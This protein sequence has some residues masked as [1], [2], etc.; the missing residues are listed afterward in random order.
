MTELKPTVEQPSPRGRR[1]VR[2]RRRSTPRAKGMRAGRLPYL[3]IV[4]AVAVLVVVVA[5]PLL[6]IVTLSLQ[7]QDSSK[8]ALFHGGGGTKFVG[9]Q[10]FTHVLGDAT[11]WAVLGR[12]FVFTA[13]NVA[14]SLM[15]GM[16]LAVLLNRVSKWARVILIVV[17]L[18]VWAVPST[19]STQVFYW[20]FSNQYGAVNYLLDQI[21]GVHMHGH[22]WF[23]DPHQGLAVISAVV[24]WG[25]IPLLA[26]SL[27]AGI[28]QIPKEIQEAAYC[29]GASAWQ[30]FRSVTFPFLKPLIVILTTLSVIWDFGV[31]NQIWF[32]RNGHPEP[33][34]QTIGIYMYS[35]GIGSSHYN[36]GATT[37]VLMMIC[38][39]FVMVFYIRQLFRIGDA[40]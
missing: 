8:Y 22:D 15:I 35:N 21:P 5:W 10:N 39:L 18:F 2:D 37:G 23:A 29:D 34:Y 20:L 27:H 30:T 40:E 19:V 31:F 28:T 7:K 38:L 17:L 24:I 32:M 11:F 6:K 4:P 16:S 33:G 26:I 13:F 25:A 9:L 1:Q 36:L 14:L 3:L 12:T